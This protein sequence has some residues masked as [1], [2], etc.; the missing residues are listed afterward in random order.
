MR[1]V[2]VTLTLTQ[3]ATVLREDSQWL[4]LAPPH[5]TPTPIPINITAANFTIFIHCTSALY[6]L[7]HGSRIVVQEHTSG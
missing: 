6:D 2:V 5:A 4:G 3:R 7:V 1:R